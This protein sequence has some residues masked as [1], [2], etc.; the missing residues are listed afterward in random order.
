MDELQNIH[1]KWHKKNNC[2][3]KPLSTQPVFGDGNPKAEIVF[4]GEAPG[5]DEDLQGKPFVGRAGKFLNEMLETIKMKR[6]DIYITNTVKYRPPDNRDPEPDEIAECLPWLMEE[7][8]FIKPKVIIFL[9]RHALN[10]FFSE[11]KISE[12]HG[13]LLHKKIEGFDT[14]YFFPLYHPAAALYNGGMRQTLLQD[15]HKIPEILKK[16]SKK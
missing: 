16:I 7:L 15:F 1:Q 12:V 5:K 11:D 9:G 14:E 4:I 13:K 10:R 6:E 3:L 8:N 2:K